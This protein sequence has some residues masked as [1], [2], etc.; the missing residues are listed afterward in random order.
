MMMNQNAEYPLKNQI[1]VI[2]QLT[3]LKLVTE[4]LKCSLTKKVDIIGLNHGVHKF[5]FVYIVILKVSISKLM[6]F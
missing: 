4:L 1:K 2:Q 5:L 3:L 6:P